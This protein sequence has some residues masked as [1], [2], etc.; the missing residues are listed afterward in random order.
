MRFKKTRSIKFVF[1]VVFAVLCTASVC[2]SINTPQLQISHYEYGKMIVNDN[3]Y[4]HDFVLWP[5]GEITPGPEDMHP[6]HLNDFDEFFK[7]GHKK[8][9]IATGDEGKV[10]LDLSRKIKKEMK[11][12]G[13][14]LLLMDTHEAVKLLNNTK[15]RDF[16][17]FVHLN[18]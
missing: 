16:V 1:Y 7:S 8:L 6:P 5:N 11:N 17:A 15:N 4:V 14:E 3:T 13:V 10:A 9:L 12:N 2:F 18:C